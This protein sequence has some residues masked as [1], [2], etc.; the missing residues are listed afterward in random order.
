[1]PTPWTILMSYCRVD[2]EREHVGAVDGE[3]V[4]R[5]EVDEVHV[6]GAVGE[7]DVTPAGDLHQ[8]D[9][10]AGQLHLSHLPTP[11]EPSAWN[12]TWP[13]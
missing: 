5:L 6:G 4:A 1:M 3:R 10:L 9:A 12:C 8:R 13:W 11:P 7:E 2:V